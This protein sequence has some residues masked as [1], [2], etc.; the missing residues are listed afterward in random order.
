MANAVLGEG[1]E[2]HIFFTFW[3]LDMIQEKAVDK[4]KSRSSAT[5]RRICPRPWV[6]FPG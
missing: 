6:A 5:P 2:T 1:I 3:G 4:L